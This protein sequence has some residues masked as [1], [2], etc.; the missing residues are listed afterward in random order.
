MYRKTLLKK[1]ST[2]E[3]WHNRLGPMARLDQLATA[4]SQ[5]IPPMKNPTT[6]FALNV[7]LLKSL[8]IHRG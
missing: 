1:G 4:A 6:I 7:P 5:P 8:W 2:L 3:D